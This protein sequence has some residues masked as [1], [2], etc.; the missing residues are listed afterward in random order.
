MTLWGQSPQ[1]PHFEEKPVELGR[2]LS[3]VPTVTH[4]SDTKLEPLRSKGHTVRLMSPTG[5]A[6][7]E[8][9][10]AVSTSQCLCS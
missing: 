5:Q 9:S 8:V 2:G 10:P 4:K 6:P 1:E 7:A 3:H